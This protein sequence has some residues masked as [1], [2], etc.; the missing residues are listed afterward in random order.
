M[1]R[2]FLNDKGL[3]NCLKIFLPMQMQYAMHV[4]IVKICKRMR[5]CRVRSPPSNLNF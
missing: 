1:A 3:C 4:F 2:L 5:L